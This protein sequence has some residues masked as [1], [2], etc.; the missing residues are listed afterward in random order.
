VNLSKK[1]GEDRLCSDGNI[2]EA[3]G[4]AKAI[5]K[6]EHN[7]GRGYIQSKSGMRSAK[8]VQTSFY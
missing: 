2:L 7:F 5:V 1:S 6:R 4:L 3:K 8:G